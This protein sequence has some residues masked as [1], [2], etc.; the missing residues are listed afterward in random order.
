MEAAVI[1]ISHIVCPVDFSEFSRH[2][3]GYAEAFAERYDSR[4]SVVHVFPPPATLDLPEP[5]E[6]NTATARARGELE[7]FVGSVNGTRRVALRAVAGSTPGKT[8]VA[9]AEEARADLLVLGS[10]GRSG[11][12]RLLLGSVTEDVIRHAPCPVLVV[13]RR[14]ADEPTAPT[15]FRRVLCAVDFSE[16]SLRA[17]EYAMA[18]AEESD[19]DLTLLHVYS[20]PPDL[21][22]DPAAGASLAGLGEPMAAAKHRLEGLVPNGLRDYCVV[23]TVVQAGAV[24][25]EI[26][27]AASALRADLIVMGVHGR[28]ALSVMMFGSNTARVVRAATCPVLVVHRH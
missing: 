23:D 18:I 7:R 15:A 9:D 28:S 16:A 1:S 5:I 25:S 12:E 14:I 4:L 19:A 8:I 27:T 6:A 13:P 24:H 22:P 11:F 20:F 17:L 2:A 26:L 21:L 10:H 3:L